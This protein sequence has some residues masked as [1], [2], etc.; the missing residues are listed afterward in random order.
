MWN[1]IRQ[2]LE[3]RIVRELAL[4][5]AGVLL[6]IF[7][8]LLIQN[9]VLDLKGVIL[10]ALVVLLILL[11]S[12]G[13]SNLWHFYNIWRRKTAFKVGILNDME[14]NKELFTGT[15]IGPEDWKKEIEE[16]ARN[17]KVDLI[18]VENYFDRYNAII[19]PYGGVYPEY[20]LKN[21][22][23]MNK[24]LSYIN[25][26]GLFVNVADIP[27]YFACNPSI[28]PWRKID[29]ALKDAP[30]AYEVNPGLIIPVKRFPLFELTPFTRELGV[31]VYNIEKDSIFNWGILDF[32]KGFEKKSEVSDLKVK[33]HRAAAVKEYLSPI[34][35]SK[36]MSL[37]PQER[38]SPLFFVRYGDGKLL[39]SLIWE[40]KQ[41]NNEVIRNELK[42]LLAKLVIDFIQ[43]K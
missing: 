35:K 31:D 40:N 25:E 1:R 24:I 39:S 13:I 5:F 7:M 34:I 15:E 43:T 21:F 42:K 30:Y 8:S 11:G 27:G 28:K 23:T 19:N 41:E 10:G 36:E 29:T 18:N 4:L 3:I 20:D 12:G 37:P 38:V 16:L 32:E 9:P 26:E 17:I 33:V 22:K 2:I 14:N 6:G